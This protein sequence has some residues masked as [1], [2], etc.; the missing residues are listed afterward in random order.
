MAK[1]CFICEKKPGSGENVSHSNKKT[2]RRW[3]PNLQ[4]IRIMVDGKKCTEYVCTKCIKA[5]K[6]KKAA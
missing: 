4:K 5:D 3:L 2:K 6:I 1:K